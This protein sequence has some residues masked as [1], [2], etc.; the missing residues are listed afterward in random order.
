MAC[1]SPHSK[2]CALDPNGVEGEMTWNVS[3]AESLRCRWSELQKSIA[4]K[5]VRRYAKT[6]EKQHSRLT[7]MAWTAL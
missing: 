5:N 4:W 7:P 6:L 3:C 2:G 1:P